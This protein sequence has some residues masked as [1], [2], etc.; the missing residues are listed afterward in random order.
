M[1]KYTARQMLAQLPL[2]RARAAL[3]TEHTAAQW[4]G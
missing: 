3:F 4:N 2:R 1:P